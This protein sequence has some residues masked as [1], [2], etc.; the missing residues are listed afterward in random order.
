MQSSSLVLVMYPCK[1]ICNRRFQYEGFSYW[2]LYYYWILLFL[3]FIAFETSACLLDWPNTIKSKV[4]VIL[5][6]NC[7]RIVFKC[8]YTK[9][10]LAFKISQSNIKQTSFNSVSVKLLCPQLNANASILTCSPCRY[11][12][13]LTGIIF[14]IFS[15]L[16]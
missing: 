16:V 2:R 12:H 9:P 14:T 11:W 5:L 7:N 1:E 3:A 4:D 15:I 10:A 13:C 6:T 8:K